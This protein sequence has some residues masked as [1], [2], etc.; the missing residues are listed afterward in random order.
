[1][2]YQRGAE[3]CVGGALAPD[4]QIDVF[5][6]GRGAVGVSSLGDLPIVSTACAARVVGD[7]Q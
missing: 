3:M 2:Q 7:V 4:V 6:E 1:M 5:G